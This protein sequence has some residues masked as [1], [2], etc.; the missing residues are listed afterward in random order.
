MS[1]EKHVLAVAG[2][3]ATTDV[4][5]AIYSFV[6]TNGAACGL[7]IAVDGSTAATHN[8]TALGTPDG[9][10]GWWATAAN[11]YMVIEPVNAMPGGGRWQV[12]IIRAST[13]ALN[14][15]W[16]PIGGWT[17]A[18]QTYAG[19]PVSAVTQW[20]DGSAPGASCTHYISGSNL[21]TYTA[22]ASTY[23]YTFLRI[24]GRRGG[25]TEDNQFV[26]G[27][28]VGGY[29]PNEPTVDTQPSVMLARYPSMA[30][31]ALSWSYGSNNSNNVN[32]APVD[33]VH[34]VTDY[35]NNGTC[36][37]QCMLPGIYGRSRSGKWVGKIIYLYNLA[38]SYELG[39]FGPTYT[40]AGGY[41]GRTDAA[42]DSAAEY[43]IGNDM[44]H[45]WKPSA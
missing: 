9:T 12:K 34:T 42:V 8:G 30:G 19:L 27:L 11:A 6:N 33:D 24:L 5:Q 10:V 35:T 26:Y 13:A 1:G 25:G 23:G 44:V 36:L 28:Y 4:M 29:V 45:R 40:M 31:A 37:A 3:G 39:S 43:I 2:S 7:R 15:V 41:L 18:A 20:N 14:A 16:A 38:S 21:E 17:V 32:R 22:G